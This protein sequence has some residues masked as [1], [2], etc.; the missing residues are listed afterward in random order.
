MNSEIIENVKMNIAKGL[1]LFDKEAIRRNIEIWRPIAGYPNY[2][3]SSFGNVKNVV[4]GKTLKPLLN[5]NGY[6]HVM[7]YN[8]SKVKTC[9]VHKLVANALLQNPE[10]KLCVD[11]KN[12]D[13]LDNNIKNLRFATH[14]ENNRNRSLSSNNTSGIKGISWYKRD[15]KWSAHIKVN[16]KKIHIGYFENIQDAHKAR[17]LKANELFGNF[18]NICEK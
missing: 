16:G 18:I 1:E 8:N 2:S 3:V 17:Q 10:N 5:K 9:K 14:R 13:R 11:H 6:Y 12:N 7:L 15:E 4:T